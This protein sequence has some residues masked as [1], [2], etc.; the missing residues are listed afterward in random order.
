MRIAL[1]LEEGKQAFAFHELFELFRIL[2][3]CREDLGKSAEKAG[4]QI[5]SLQRSCEEFAA[6][7]CQGPAA[8]ENPVPFYAYANNSASGGRLICLER[9]LAQARLPEWAEAAMGRARYRI[10]VD[11]G[12][13]RKKSGNK[14]KT[15]LG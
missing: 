2:F 3:T 4:A 15:R 5:I 12:S 8:Q 7:H 11:S 1:R 6:Q 14:I 13:R 10:L 9:V